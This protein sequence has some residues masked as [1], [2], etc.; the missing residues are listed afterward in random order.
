MT[1]SGVIEPGHLPR[2]IMAP[3]DS[4]A[5]TPSLNMSIDDWLQKSEKQMIADA[6]QRAGGIQVQAAELL[7]INP[8]SL[9]H[10]IKKHGID[11]ASF[12]K[13]QNL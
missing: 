9:W 7:G 13:Q 8:R 10:R 2:R 5:T 4:K 3:H 11:A 12:K 6:L 1:E